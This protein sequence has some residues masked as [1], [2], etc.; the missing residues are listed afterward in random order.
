M[1]KIL[2]A[3]AVVAVGAFVLAGAGAGATPSSGTLG[4]TAGTANWTG[5]HYAAAAVA[6]PT[7]CPPA[8][9]DP[10]NLVCDH[11]S[12][13]VNVD[14]SYWNTNSGGASVTISW[15]SN[16]NDFDLYVYDS[17][18]NEVA[19][20]AAGGT[21]S[22][23]LMI[24]N[25][26]GTYDVVV[27]PFLVTDSG[28]SATASFVSQA[29]A[30]GSP[31]GPVAYHGVAVA[32]ANPAAAPQTTAIKNYKG[33]YPTFQWVD[34]GRQAAEPTVGVDKTGAAFYAAATFDSV[35]NEAHTLVMRSTDS[36]LTWQV[37]Q[38]HVGDTQIDA[39]PQTLDPYVYVDE[40]S[41]RVFDVDTLA[42]ASMDLSYSDNQGATWFTTL[43]VDPEVTDHQTLYAAAPPAANPAVKPILPN[44]QKIVYFCVNSVVD[45][46][47]NRSVDGG[48]TWTRTGGP[49][50]LGFDVAAG[51]LC[52][53]LH[54]HLGADSAGRIFVPKGHCG[55]PWMA[56][57]ADGGT[58]WTRVQVSKTIGSAD[59]QTAVAVDKADNLYY[60]WWDD[61]HHL[62]YLSIS[63]DHGT[64][65]S[66][67]LMIAPP[68][69]QEVNFPTITAGDSGRIAITFPGTTVSDRGDKTRPWDTY[70][71]ISTNALDSDPTFVSNI[72]NP[73][74]DPIHRGDCLGR[75][76]GMFDFLDIVSA[77]TD[78]SV[79]ATAVDTCTSQDSC[80]TVRAD[81][82]NDDTGSEGVAS[83]M[84]GM[85][86]KE[87]SGPKLLATPTNCKK[88]KP[89]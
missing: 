41:G 28:Y 68:G 42:A 15:A 53:G 8:S 17:S 59:I 83:D 81:D 11:F 31:T 86:A 79:W 7:A 25:A 66:T 54:G 50:Y 48:N 39:H 62:P 88:N 51:G 77:P 52:G 18:G 60:V 43:A 23:Q 46:G 74:G 6:D 56:S 63:R 10:Q 9:L 75:C 71:V 24:S 69:V 58:T 30:G 32:G 40:A 73:A 47:C 37:T 80:N 16:A 65:W 87:I 29:G 84:R 44:F 89:C 22:E 33:A 70:V 14:P 5:Q 2:A 1:K 49:A 78:G 45:S 4:P 19:H 64:T 12:L 34:V 76:A 67:P 55:F 85:V 21:T 35:I 26:A 57:S 61:V 3:L 72:A 36:G 38:P 82:N 27:V 13:T 20:S